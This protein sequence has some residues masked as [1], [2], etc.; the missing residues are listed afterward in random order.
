MIGDTS[1]GG[2]GRPS[3]GVITQQVSIGVTRRHQIG[4]DDAPDDGDLV[5][6]G[7]REGVRHT[8]VGPQGPQSSRHS[9]H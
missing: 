9:T 6:V 3:F 2:E 4:V 5:N 1:T 7:L 8:F